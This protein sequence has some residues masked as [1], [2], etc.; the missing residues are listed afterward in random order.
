MK[1]LEFEVIRNPPL[2]AGETCWVEMNKASGVDHT[3]SCSGLNWAVET[4]TF[5]SN[6]IS[7]I[8][9]PCLY[10]IGIELY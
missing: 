4:T 3:C 10:I 2:D 9:S 6:W 8:N 5:Q 1:G 7:Y